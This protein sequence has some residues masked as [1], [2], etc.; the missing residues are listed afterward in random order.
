MSGEVRTEIEQN[1]V[2]RPCYHDK[3]FGKV[4]PAQIFK[5]MNNKIRFMSSL[6]WVTGA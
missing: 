1:P 2:T 3:R 4:D 5:Q 6:R